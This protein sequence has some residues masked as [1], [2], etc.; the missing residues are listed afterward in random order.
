MERRVN[1]PRVSELRLALIHHLVQRLSD[2]GKIKVQKLVYFLQEA[3]SVP[4]GYTFRMHHYGPYSEELDTDVDRLQSTGYVKVVRDSE[5]YGFHI[6]T[7]NEPEQGWAGLVEPHTEQIDRVLELLGERLASELE[8][9]ATIHFVS[10]LLDKPSR[11]GLLEAVRSLKPRFEESYIDELR[12]E[13][14]KEGLLKT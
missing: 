8:L 2:V 4:V 7:A 14:E 11:K 12:E 5:G 3:L 6:R 13:L 9:A 1:R 10:Q